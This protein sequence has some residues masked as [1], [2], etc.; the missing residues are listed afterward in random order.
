MNTKSFSLILIFI[1]ILI[2]L[3]NG[4]MINEEDSSIKVINSEYFFNLYDD[5]DIIINKIGEPKSNYDEDSKTYT[6]T[7]ENGLSIQAINGHYIC[8]IK[9][10]SSNFQTKKSICVGDSYSKVLRIYGRPQFK[11]ETILSYSIN[12]N[13]GTVIIFKFDNNKV[14]EIILGYS[15]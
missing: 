1:S 3:C 13:R 9:I 14:K 8:Y 10:S 11:Y 5:L 7:W 6:F 12:V 15:S 4:Q 2:S